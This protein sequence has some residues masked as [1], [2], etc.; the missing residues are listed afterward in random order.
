MTHVRD[1]LERIYGRHK[2][3]LFVL[4]LSITHSPSDAE[5]AIH[6]AFAR[7][8]RAPNTMPADPVAYVF[9]A[10]RNAAI[11]RL[12]QRSPDAPPLPTLSSCLDSSDHAATKERDQAIARAIDTLPEELRMIVLLRVFSALTFRHIGELT[13]TPTQ[14]VVSRYVA[15]LEQLRPQLRNML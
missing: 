7:L 11:D 8:I 1:A 9:A 15:A 4:A 13:E 6:D 5:D 12:R 10:V 14:T 3:G 2:Q